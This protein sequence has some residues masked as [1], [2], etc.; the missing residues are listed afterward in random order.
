MLCLW[1][2]VSTRFR[3]NER[4]GK[5]LTTYREGKSLLVFPHPPS[6]CSTKNNGNPLKYEICLITQNEFFAAEIPVGDW[7]RRGLCS[8]SLVIKLWSLNAALPCEKLLK[9]WLEQSSACRFSL[10]IENYFAFWHLPK[11]S[12]VWFDEKSSSHW[13]NNSPFM[14]ALVFFNKKREDIFAYNRKHI[15]GRVWILLGW[16]MN[17][18]LVRGIGWKCIMCG[19]ERGGCGGSES[20]LRTT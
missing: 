5:K 14:C 10:G 7:W 8:S 12:F 19:K 16:E 13:I 15:F 9:H 4:I 17:Q 2:P 18:G 3:G 20:W 6:C 11:H 1:H